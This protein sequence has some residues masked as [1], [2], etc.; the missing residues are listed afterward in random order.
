M[1]RQMQWAWSERHVEPARFHPRRRFK[2]ATEGLQRK[3]HVLLRQAG[4]VADAK[5]HR[6]ARIRGDAGREVG[7]RETALATAQRYEVVG[8]GFL[9][10]LARSFHPVEPHVL[11]HK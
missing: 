4:G 1:R 3:D 9:L 6:V 11:D 8:H 5:L 7:L 10:A 2:K